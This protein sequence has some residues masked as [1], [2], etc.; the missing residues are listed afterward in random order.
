M[1]HTGGYFVVLL[2][3]TYNTYNYTTYN[4]NLMLMMLN[5][6]LKSFKYQNRILKCS[7]IKRILVVLGF[8]VLMQ[9]WNQHN[10]KTPNFN[11][12]T[13][14]VSFNTLLNV[15]LLLLFKQQIVT[16]FFGKKIEPLKYL[17]L[18]FWENPYRFYVQHYSMFSSSQLNAPSSGAPEFSREIMVFHL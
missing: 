11:S 15:L 4:K 12:T 3:K 8:Q 14:N 6:S 2:K 5:K 10:D 17:G 7:Q 16:T 13:T 9:Y 18:Y 1:L